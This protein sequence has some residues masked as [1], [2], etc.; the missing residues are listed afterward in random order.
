MIIYILYYL[1]I[2]ILL[3][4]VRDLYYHDMYYKGCG[5]LCTHKKSFNTA[6]PVRSLGAYIFTFS[7]FD[8]LFYVNDCDVHILFLVI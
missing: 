6:I 8:L 5:L 4:L 1:V 3:S 7:F 2:K